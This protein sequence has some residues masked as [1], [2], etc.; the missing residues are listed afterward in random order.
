MKR[1]GITGGIGSGKSV[2]AQLLTTFGIPVYI[3]DEE[4]KRLTNTSPR[5]REGLCA[6]FGSEI[7]TER[8]L[9]K[10]RL[11][12][13]IFSDRA[14]LERVNRLI[15]PVVQADFDAWCRRQSA[16]FCA[17]ESAILFESGFDHIV[18]VRLLVYAPLEVRLRRATERDQAPREAIL[19]R[20]QYQMPDEDKR[21]LSDYTILND[22]CAALI[23]QVEQFVF[24][25]LPSRKVEIGK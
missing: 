11:A 9:D 24:T 22:D 15:H 4:S 25:F 3:A 14:Q 12:A 2:V 21:R 10:S 1:I 5:I 20:I 8:G 13:A 23:P 17:L 6:L 19:R 7:Y 18:D 16:P